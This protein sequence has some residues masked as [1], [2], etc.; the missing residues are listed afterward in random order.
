MACATTPEQ[1]FPATHIRAHL[2]FLADDLLEGREAGTR[3]YDIAAN[4]V[5]THFKLIG[6]QPAGTHGYFQRVPLRRSVLRPG[7]VSLQVRTSRG[8]QTFTDSDHVAARPSMTEAEQ[9]VE[10]DCVFAGYGIVAPELRRDDYA[11]LDVRDKIVVV[12][13]GP[14]PGLPSEIAAHL[15][16]AAE[17]RAR[18][19]ERGAI[20]MFIVYTPALEARW[21]FAKLPEIYRQP[22]FDW[23]DADV[24]QDAQSS[25]RVAALVDTTAA[26]AL[27]EGAPRGFDEVMREARTRPPAGFPLRTGA[28]FSRGS[29]HSDSTSANVV[30]LLPGSDPALANE[31]I[32]FTS[33]LDH[34]G[35]GTAR[36]GDV[37]YN[38]A[39]DNGVGIATMIEVAR[40]LKT[41][42]QPLRRSVLFVATTAEEKGLI[43]SD[44]FARKPTLPRERLVGVINLDG[45]MPF[46]DLVEVIGYG[47]AS[48]TLGQTLARAATSLGI[49]VSPDPAPEQG[50][51]TRS[52][53][54]PFV[55]QGIPGIFLIAGDAR[56]PDGK[57]AGEISR[58][59]AE[60]HLHQPSDDLNQPFHDPHLE[61]WAQLYWRWTVEAANAPEP[62]LWYAGD[63]F[64]N[65]YAPGARKAS[66]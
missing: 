50:Y 23:S 61:K 37:I 60:Q 56:T 3:G 22:Q 25:L 49:S 14:A 19:A 12:L 42:N 41:A 52:D 20:G 33:H 26:A 53:H 65:R 16:D 44:Y 43:G 11:R 10:A 9:R 34:V 58:R 13:G 27:F 62:P 51:F 38:G 57:D 7:T 8:T 40:A 32:V 2:E 21:P 45:A 31:V 30:A 48:S 35:I 29:Q 1:P 4:Y 59:W 36:N 5:A 17:Q 55:R 28:T 24:K 18:A 63:F 64:G 54:Y 39:L 15:G 46:F 6:L 47:A 66:R